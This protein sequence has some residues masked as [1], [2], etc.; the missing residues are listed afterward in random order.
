[1]SKRELPKSYVA[2]YW[3]IWGGF[4]AALIALRIVLAAFALKQG[5]PFILVLYFTLFGVPMLVLSL[6]EI[7]RTQSYMWRHHKYRLGFSNLAISMFIHSSQEFNDPGV[8]ILR[9]NLRQVRRLI[10]TGVAM[11]MALS[12]LN[13]TLFGS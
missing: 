9:E 13:F 3:K 12:I 5:G 10:W 1:M 4:V 11:M 6:V 8:P 2:I 7:G